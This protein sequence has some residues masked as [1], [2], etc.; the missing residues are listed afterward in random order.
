VPAERSLAWG[1]LPIGLA[2]KV[3]LQRDIATGETVRWAD[4]AIPDSPALEARRTMERRF[5]ARPSAI[6]A[7]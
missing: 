5:A 6:A 4:V 1:A 7:K 2:H 3:P